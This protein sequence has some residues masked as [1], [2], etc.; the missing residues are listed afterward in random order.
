MVGQNIFKR[1]VGGTPVCLSSELPNIDTQT[2]SI[3]SQH[4]LFII[5]KSSISRCFYAGNET[6]GVSCDY[7]KEHPKKTTHPRWAGGARGWAGIT[8]QSDLVSSVFFTLLSTHPLCITI[9]SIFLP[10]QTSNDSLP[11]Q[12]SVFDDAWCKFG[13]LI[14]VSIAHFW[15]AFME[16]DVIMF[17]KYRE[18]AKCVKKFTPF[19]CT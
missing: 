10:P 2:L 3:D 8:I 16:F 12:G 15:N 14:T 11:N 17:V 9:S 1:R 4:F 6:V 13:P 7:K 5:S 18:A 19:F